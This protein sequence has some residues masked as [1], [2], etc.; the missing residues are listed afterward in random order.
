MS[1]PNQAPNQA[2]NDLV[3]LNQLHHPVRPDGQAM[4]RNEVTQITANQ[5]QIRDGL[6][7]FDNVFDAQLAVS[8][9]KLHDSYFNNEQAEASAA[10]TGN[11]GSAAAE[12][13]AE[14]A[15]AKQLACD[16]ALD[17]L[18]KLVEDG[19]TLDGPTLSKAGIGFMKQQELGFGSFDVMKQAATEKAAKAA[20]AQRVKEYHEANNAKAEAW[21]A[22]TAA[23]R[24]G[25]QT[26][27]ERVEK[28]VDGSA[29]VEGLSYKERL[30]QGGELGVKFQQEHSKLSRED[31]IAQAAAEGHDVSHTETRHYKVARNEAAEARAAEMA[32]ALKDFHKQVFGANASE[33]APDVADAEPELAPLPLPLDIAPDSRQVSRSQESLVQGATKA[34]SMLGRMKDKL[35]AKGVELT[36][37]I[38]QKL[39]GKFETGTLD[40]TTY[41]RNQ[42]LLTGVI[43]GSAAMYLT[44][45]FAGA[46]LPFFGGGVA[47]AANEH[48]NGNGASGALSVLGERGNGGGHEPLSVLDGRGNGGGAGA[49]E[50]A[51]LQS[52]ESVWSEAADA[53]PKGATTA[54]VDQIKDAILQKNGI[55]EAQATHLPVGTELDMPTNLIDHIEEEAKKAKAA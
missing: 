50:T 6:G 12:K 25:R 10:E 48:G 34:K 42:R 17:T 33:A 45:R 21:K 36:N 53:A 52:G 5:D 14:E 44:T 38:N 37:A 16:E 28:L 55:S 51:T 2:I 3:E 35:M 15:A 27:D 13:A 22:E 24:D 7:E 4:S 9:Q 11:D 1:N 49:H 39:S 30:E 23:W 8:A 19:K 20:E 31:A 40:E 32:A 54:Q 18:N 43:M 26:T 47:Q 29:A 41:R 46:E